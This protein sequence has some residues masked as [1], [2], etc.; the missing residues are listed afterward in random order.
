MIPSYWKAL[1][2]SG[3]I[4]EKDYF[5]KVEPCNVLIKRAKDRL[6]SEFLKGLKRAYKMNSGGLCRSAV[7]KEI[8]KWEGKLK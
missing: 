4:T 6:I 2:K 7:W 5:E 3:S 8:E 1:I